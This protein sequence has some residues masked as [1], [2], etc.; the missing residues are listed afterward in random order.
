LLTVLDSR[1]L[2]EEVELELLVAELELLFVG[3]EL[4]VEVSV[5][6]VVEVAEVE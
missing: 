2:V 5:T 6:V 3:S 1:L 4:V